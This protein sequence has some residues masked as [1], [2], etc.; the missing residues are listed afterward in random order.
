M[1]V[2]TAQDPRSVVKKAIMRCPPML[3]S[4]GSFGPTGPR[5]VP[6]SSA[7][8]AT[9]MAATPARAQSAGRILEREMWTIELASFQNRARN[10]SVLHATLTIAAPRK[11]MLQCKT[12]R[13]GRKRNERFEIQN[14]EF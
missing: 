8:P 5:L 4:M 14:T 1:I 13:R 11:F 7:A 6:Y 9:L 12:S 3:A 2:L 10:R